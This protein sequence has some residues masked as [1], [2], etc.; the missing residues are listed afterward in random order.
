MVE[1]SSVVERRLLIVPVLADKLFVRRC[2]VVILSVI[3]APPDISK[4]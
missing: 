1:I 4:V 2:P 3:L